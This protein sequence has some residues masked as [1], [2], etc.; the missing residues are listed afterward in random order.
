MARD[1]VAVIE[2][3]ELA[4]VNAYFSSAVYREAY[5]I[6]FDFRDRSELAVSDPFRSKRSANLEAGRLLRRLALPRS[7]RSH[8]TVAS[9]CK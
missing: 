2:V 4:K 7:K 5:L 8:R 3:T 1:G 6:R 9:G